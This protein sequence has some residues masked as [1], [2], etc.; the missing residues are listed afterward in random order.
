MTIEKIAEKIARRYEMTIEYHAASVSIETVE[1][2]DQDDA[3]FLYSVCKT[4]GLDMKVFQ[5]KLIIYDPAL[6]EQK[7][8]VA[9][10]TPKSFVDSEWSITD[11]LDGVYNGCYVR[12]GS[13][14]SSKKYYYGTVDKSSASARIVRQRVTAQN[15]AEAK[16]KALSAIN[17]SNEGAVKMSGDIWPTP[18]ITAG[19]CVV[20]KDFGEPDGK[21]FVER[22]SFS[23]DPNDTKM[24]V[25]M[26]KIFARVRKV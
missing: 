5:D 6:L 3:A 16:Y 2:T 9:T 22:V 18:A 13:G 8:P 7:E 21:Y 20:V 19:T 12:V 4:Y 26:H 15:A 25:T 10:L 17:A 23:I 14:T 11:T 1:Q 24:S